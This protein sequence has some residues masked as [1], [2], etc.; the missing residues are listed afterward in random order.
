MKHQQG[1]FSAVLIVAPAF[2]AALPPAEGCYPRVTCIGAEHA[3]SGCEK[4]TGI[5]SY[6]A[7][8]REGEA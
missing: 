8:K 6:Q 1:C 3:S 4:A 2:V 7:R 5:V